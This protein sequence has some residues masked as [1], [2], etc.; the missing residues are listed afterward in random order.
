MPLNVKPRNVSI[1]S[2]IEA[3]ITERVTSD[4]FRSAREETSGQGNRE[5][6]LP[7]WFPARSET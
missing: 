6:N 1:T 5:S 4:R 7:T 3:F 2:E